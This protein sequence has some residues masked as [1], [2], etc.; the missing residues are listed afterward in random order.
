MMEPMPRKNKD[1]TLPP[2]PSSVSVEDL[3]RAMLRTP[4][5][6]A[7]DPSTRKQKPKRKPVRKKN[8]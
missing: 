7:G 2:L 1:T 4:P 3:L 6:P 5:P 8:G